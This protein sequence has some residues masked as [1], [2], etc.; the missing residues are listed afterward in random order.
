MTLLLGQPSSVAW[1]GQE[2]PLFRF[3]SRNVDKGLVLNHMH[4]L[5]TVL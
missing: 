4:L 5:M 1:L 2:V 3:I